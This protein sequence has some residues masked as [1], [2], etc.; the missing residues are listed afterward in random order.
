MQLKYQFWNRRT[1]QLLLIAGLFGLSSTHSLAQSQTV[2]S[3]VAEDRLVQRVKEELM[4]E[5]QEGKFL[6]Q[7]IEL[8]IQEF[9]RKQ[10]AVANEAENNQRR[11]ADE[12]VAQVRPLSID[13]DHIYGNPNA[14]VSLIEYS[15]FECPYCKSFHATAKNLVDAYDGQ[16]N[17]VY[18]HYP[19]NFHNPGAQSQAEASEC[20]NEIGGNDMFWLY[21]N[22]IYERTTSNGKGFPIEDLVPLAVELGMNKNIFDLCLDSG[23]YSERVKSDLVEGSR[24]GVTG[25]PGNILLNN[26]TGTAR[27][28][29]GTLPLDALRAVVE[30]L[31]VI[32]Q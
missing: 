26:R 28:R 8:G 29:A 10:Q 1:L 14:D 27:L 11:L 23:R 15:D 32:K 30:E 25:T 9:I 24:I 13:R 20:A 19:L 17:W 22:A 21:T 31:L 6:Q 16:V 5:L 4:K 3:A 2:D 7:Q 12:R 18:R